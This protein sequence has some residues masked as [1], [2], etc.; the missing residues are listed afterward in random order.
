MVTLAHRLLNSTLGPDPVTAG[1]GLFL[2][3]EPYFLT[4][5][6]GGIAT[7]HCLA[8]A[9]PQ[10]KHW[11]AYMLFTPLGLCPKCVNA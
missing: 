5:I 10:L 8:L 3:Q 6:G 11:N 1:S 2:L 9:L 7:G 4:V